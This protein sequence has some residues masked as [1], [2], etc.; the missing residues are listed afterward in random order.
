[1]IFPFYPM[2]DDTN[3]DFNFQPPFFPTQPVPN[4]FA[5][6]LACAWQGT[7]AAGSADVPATVE[8]AGFGPA[9]DGGKTIGFQPRPPEIVGILRAKTES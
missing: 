4:D 7:D 2:I 9:N 1:M 8:E 5:M 6:R 3:S